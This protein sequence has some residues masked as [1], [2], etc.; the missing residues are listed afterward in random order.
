M[1]NKSFLIQPISSLCGHAPVH[2]HM[3]KLLYQSPSK[4]FTKIHIARRF[5]EGWD[6]CDKERKV[7][8]IYFT[9]TSTITT[10]WLI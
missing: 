3:Y 1:N 6:V 9:F 5:A 2:K 8:E 7:Q 4:K 10:G